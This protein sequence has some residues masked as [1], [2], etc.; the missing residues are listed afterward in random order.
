ML[1]ALA[2]LARAAIDPR[3]PLP[4]SVPLPAALSADA[5]LL[6]LKGGAF[7]PL[8]Q[9]LDFSATGAAATV[10]ARYALVQFKAGTLAPRAHLQRLG[11]DVV[12]YVPNNAYQVRLNAGNLDGLRADPAVRWADAITAGMKLD[13][14]LW[15]GNAA[16]PGTDAA[17]DAKAIVVVHGFAGESAGTLAGALKKSV[18][19]AMVVLINERADAPRV[20]VRVPA[21]E[22][23]RLIAAATA[24]DGVAWVE[25]FRQPRVSND[26][27][28]GPLQGD[29]ATCATPVPPASGQM[30]FPCASTPM[31]DYGLVGNGQI[32]GIADTGLD[33]NAA[34]FSAYTFANPG[35]GTT[36]NVEITAADNPAPVPPAIGLT[37]PQN[38][39][40][41]YWVQPGATAYDNTQICPGGFPNEFHGTHTSGTLA[42]DAA[43]TFG[44]ITYLAATPTNPN[45][46][47]GDGMAPNA[48]ILFQDIGND[49]DGCLYINDLRATLDQAFAGG[50]RIHSDSWGS[51]DGG[52]YEGDDADVDAEMWKL[53]DM[54]IAVAAGN[55]GP[56][57]VSTGSPGNAKNALTV[58]ALGHDVSQIVASFSSRGPTADG[59][60]KP[61]IVAPG[62]NIVSAL[63]DSS[64]GAT[65]EAPQTQALSGTSMATPTTAGNAALMREY[66]S[67]GFYP[68]GTRNGGD[69]LNPSGMLMKAVLL[70]G[71]LTIPPTW[72]DDNVGWG[73]MWLASNLYFDYAPDGSGSGSTRRMRYWERPNSAG[74]ATGDVHTYTLANVQ[75]SQE[76]RVTL[77]WYD[78]AAAL[79]AA[80][81]LVNNLDLEVVAPDGTLYRGNVFQNA[82]S[83]AGGSAD[84][85]NTVEAVRLIAPVGGAY[86]LRVRATGVPGNGD[87]GSD[88]QGYALVASGAFGLPDQAALPA[89]TDVAVRADDLGGIVIGFTPAPAAQAYQLYRAAG[90]CATALQGDF[91]MVATA[92][93]GSLTDTLSQGGYSY[94]YEVRGVSND[95]E[96]EHSSCVDAVSNAACTLQPSFDQAGIAAAGANASCSVNLTWPAATSNCPAAPGIHFQVSRDTH[97]YFTAPG[98]I[99]SSVTAETYADTAVVDGQPYYYQIIALDGANNASVPMRTVGTT[100]SGA[101]GP[102]GSSYLDDVDTHTYLALDP[103]WQITN[104]AASNG[105]YSYHSAADNQSYPSNTCAAATT[106]ALTLT[107]HPQ[108]SY[109]AQYNLES[110]WDGVVVEISTDGTNWNDLPPTGGYPDALSQ[111]QSPPVNACGYAAT[112]GAFTGKS[113]AAS[114]SA[115]NDDPAPLAFRRFG[116]DLSAYAGQKVQIRFRLSSDPATEFAGFFLDEVRVNDADEIFADGFEGPG[117]NVCH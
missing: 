11:A 86:T 21:T 42:G 106:P 92:S 109:A 44:G 17:A 37:Y 4:A 53:Q 36:T 56:S 40:Y 70:N 85:V 81:A 49:N 79:G 47:H 113:T 89:P 27:S 1:C 35:G 108:L 94:A 96:G 43:G 63:G 74:M 25:P 24:L 15:S 103:P 80:V 91:R 7:D 114:A 45:H 73:R 83:V 102:G 99:A 60:L 61:D 31:W 52:E 68:R 6:L 95:V 75:A 58:G 82:V 97:P 18:G 41:A 88:A 13:P 66:F 77:V 76:F 115:A 65:I 84:V 72:P 14:A 3:M 19:D 98:V 110:E 22:L 2:P 16:S 34:W 28:P 105:S 32:L 38:K 23:S 69:T 93:G 5:G 117:A 104:T 55:S 20:R 8:V 30:P 26:G 59:R 51:A 57:S 67:E 12:G 33:H 62:V 9:R 48:Q 39:V 87:A 50:A 107:A 29:A 101:A 54:L 112:Q 64:N 90:T 46:D 78:P 71:T 116:S 100:P 10:D 111:T